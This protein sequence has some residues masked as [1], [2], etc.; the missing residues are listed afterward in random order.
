MQRSSC[1]QYYFGHQMGETRLWKGI[2]LL[3]KIARVILSTAEFLSVYLNLGGERIQKKP[4]QR[5]NITPKS[6][7]DEDAY[8]YPNSCLDS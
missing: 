4:D 7:T 2:P 1:F 8:S 3:K 5:Y 6:S